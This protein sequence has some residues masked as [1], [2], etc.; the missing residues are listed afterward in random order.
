MLDLFAAFP[1][2]LLWSIALVF[3]YRHKTPFFLYVVIAVTIVTATVFLPERLPLICWLPDGISV[4][5]TSTLLILFSA[6][7]Q[8]RVLGQEAIETI[9]DRKTIRE[10]LAKIE[11]IDQKQ[12]YYMKTVRVMAYLLSRNDKHLARPNT[13]FLITSISMLFL[14]DFNVLYFG[15][16]DTPV[17]KETYNTYLN[18]FFNPEVIGADKAEPARLEFTTTL[19]RY[20]ASMIFATISVIFLFVSMLVRRVLYS[21]GIKNSDLGGLAHFKLSD[22]FIWSY[23]PVGMLY[24]GSF[25]IAVPEIVRFVI[26][27]IFWILTV[28]YI[29]QGASITY[30]FFTTRLFPL[31]IT[32]ILT[33]TL[34]LF[35]PFA[36]ITTVTALAMI[37]LLDFWFDFRKKALQPKLISD[38]ASY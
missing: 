38:D 31:Q 8:N 29:F 33:F 15:F 32:V 4:V 37:G 10:D 5:L 18:L 6:R 26:E 28:L 36:F 19:L 2:N 35:F 34:S 12:D 13:L 22:L 25:H 23:I 11:S 3:I 30:L 20:S 27:N 14:L 17:F 24:A 9:P 16:F 1:G 7:E 21:R